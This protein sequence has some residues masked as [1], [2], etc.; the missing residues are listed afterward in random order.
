MSEG[1]ST[2]HLRH[3]DRAPGHPLAVSNVPPQAGVAAS[4]A[5]PGAVAASG[6]DWVVLDSFAQRLR[7]LLWRPPPLP[8]QAWC[9]PRCAAVHTWGMAHPIDIV[10]VAGKGEIR[11]VDAAVPPWRWRACPGARAVV[12]LTAGEAARLGW[13]C[14]SHV[15]WPDGLLA[16]QICDK[17]L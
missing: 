14:G 17:N 1:W 6:I 9:L 5:R 3:R 11:R 10:F 4:A 8:A 2:R 15:A 7:G 12:E 16:R 13:H